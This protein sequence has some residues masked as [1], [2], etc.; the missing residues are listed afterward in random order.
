VSTIKHIIATIQHD[1]FL[2]PLGVESRVT[3][4]T[5]YARQPRISTFKKPTVRS[6]FSYRIAL[7]RRSLKL[8]KIIMVNS[9]S[10]VPSDQ[11]PRVF[12]QRI[13]HH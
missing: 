11:N 8:R 4:A 7:T 5:V 2:H 3:L 6:F 1:G 10:T 9:I 12:T 13:L